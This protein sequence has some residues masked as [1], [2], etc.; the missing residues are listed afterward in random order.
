MMFLYAV[1]LNRLSLGIYRRTLLMIDTVNEFHFALLLEQVFAKHFN[2]GAVRTADGL[3]TVHII[4]YHSVS[5]MI[6]S[7]S[8]FSW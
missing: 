1:L 3:N 8:F 4:P 2:I 6:S 5:F 7:L